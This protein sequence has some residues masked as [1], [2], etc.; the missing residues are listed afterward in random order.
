LVAVLTAVFTD[1]R[2]D[3]ALERE[4]GRQRTA[5]ESEAKRQQATLAA[6]RERLVLQLDHDRRLADVADLRRVL[7]ES[8]RTA[9][10]RRAILRSARE[11]REQATEE[12]LTKFQEARFSIDA[13]RIRLHVDDP[14]YQVMARLDTVLADLSRAVTSTD[15]QQWNAADQTWRTT[16]NEAVRAAQLR[17]GA[18]LD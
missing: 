6:E 5:L 8:F 14:L 2:Q 12:L 7:E 15:E 18:R 3:V 17:V 13:F 16:Y 4:D 1:R 9:H 11:R 10:E